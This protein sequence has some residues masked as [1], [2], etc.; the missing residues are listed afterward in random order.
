MLSRAITLRV[1]G[2][3]IIQRMVRRSFL[4][5]PLVRRFIA[6]EDL[7]T[8]VKI[9]EDLVA[10]GYNVSLDFLGENTSDAAD[11][12]A[13]KQTYVTMLE[14]ISKSPCAAK[15][16]ISIKLTQCGLD[17]GEDVAANHLSEVL[18]TAERLNNFVRVDMES[19]A[20]TESTLNVIGKVWDRHKNVGTVLQ[21]YLYRTPKDV[22]RCLA[23]GVRLRL[24]KGAYLE[25]ASVAYPKK[26]DVDE[27]YITLAKRL[28]DSGLYHAIASHDVKILDKV[29]AYVEEKGISKDAFEFQ[30]I[31]GVR[32]DLQEKLRSEGYNVRIYVPYGEQWYPYFTR[33]LAERPANVF[34]IA[35]SM[36]R[37]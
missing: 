37:G 22:E 23:M 3:G 24:V 10:K 14:R 9:A 8:A 30:V 20:Y 36:F 34:F 17:L 25:A 33:R 1:F 6:G 21:S 16:N 19:S 27:A 5:R 29:K 32:R 18:E 11:A 26:R 35:K 28:L 7:E 15:T 31:Y 13:A 4:F 12:E 2:V